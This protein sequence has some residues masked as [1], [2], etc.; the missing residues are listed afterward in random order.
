MLVWRSLH[1]AKLPQTVGTWRSDG[2]A[3]ENMIDHGRHLIHV[4][5]QPTVPPPAIH[6]RWAVNGV[7]AWMTAYPDII[8]ISLNWGFGDSCQLD[9]L[10]LGLRGYCNVC[11]SLPGLNRTVLPGR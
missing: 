3:N 2:R 6:P 11:S 1:Q 9:D 8:L 10:Q 4:V 5:I 7:S